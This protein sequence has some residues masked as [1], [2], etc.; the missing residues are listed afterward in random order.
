M[1]G[2]LLEDARPGVGRMFAHLQE[3]GVLL[4]TGRAKRVGDL[5]Q[6]PTEYTTGHAPCKDGD[7]QIYAPR[8]SQKPK[9]HKEP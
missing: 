5:S 6:D 4:A 3:V 9:H 2:E 8:Q 1:H 7:A